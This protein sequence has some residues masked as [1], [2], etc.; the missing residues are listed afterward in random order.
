MQERIRLDNIPFN[1]LLKYL[2][3]TEIVNIQNIYFHIFEIYM[4]LFKV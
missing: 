1:I 2:N 4:I 3:H